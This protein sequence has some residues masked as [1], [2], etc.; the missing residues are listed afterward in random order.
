MFLR[1]SSS[2]CHLDL[3]YWGSYQC[4]MGMRGEL[5]IATQLP[6]SAAVY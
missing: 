6:G 4:A 5:E 3:I 1:D 2:F